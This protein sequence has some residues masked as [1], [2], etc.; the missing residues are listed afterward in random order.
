MSKHTIYT[1][2]RCG[3]E[4]KDRMGC[5]NIHADNGYGPTKSIRDLCPR[6]MSYVDWLLNE[7][8]HGTVEKEAK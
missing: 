3:A 2:D 6:C 8:C 4:Q 5:W 1:C 7:A